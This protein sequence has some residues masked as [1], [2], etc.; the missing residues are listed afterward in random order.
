[1]RDLRTEV[2]TRATETTDYFN[3]IWG[4]LTDM[5]SALSLHVYPRKK[6]RPAAFSPPSR[7][8]TIDPHAAEFRAAMD[9]SRREHEE[10][11]R[12]ERDPKGKGISSAQDDDDSDSD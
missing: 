2:A 10:R 5:R 11:M 12:A 6:K 8:P 1:M 3:D 7:G 4:N 9:R